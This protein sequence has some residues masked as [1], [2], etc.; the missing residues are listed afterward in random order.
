MAHV[1]EV[2]PDLFRISTF[3]P[4]ADLTFNQFLVRD[5]EP[6]LFHTGLRK[7]FPAVRDAVAT[8]LDPR[9]IRWLTWSH[10]E[11]DECGSLNEWLALAP[12]A[13]AACGLVAAVVSVDDVADRPAR[14]LQPGEVLT[15]GRYRFRYC[16]TPHVPHGWDA[17]LLFEESERTL[18]CSDLLQQNG[19]VEPLTTSDVVG[20]FRAALLA[21][22][23]GPFANYLP[24]TPMTDAILA[25]LAALAPKTLAIM[26]GSTFVG[27][28][29]A[30]LRQCAGIF[31]DVFTKPTEGR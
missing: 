23:A 25:D 14:Q 21:Y 4:E 27:D 16:R 22:Q 2:A 8:V 5:E 12:R 26:H 3:V 30:A 7:L 29:A 15:T 19:E 13:Q 20:P 31:R 24:Y 6:L 1:T 10:Y 9:T 11:A 17:G 28:G 18:L